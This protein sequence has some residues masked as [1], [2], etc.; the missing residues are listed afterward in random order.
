MQRSDLVKTYYNKVVE[1]YYNRRKKMFTI[2][3]PGSKKVLGYEERVVISNVRFGFRKVRTIDK[4]GKPHY[5]PPLII[6]NLIHDDDKDLDNLKHFDALTYNVKQ[7]TT[8]VT[9]D[10]KKA[11]DLPYH[12]AFCSLNRVGLPIYVGAW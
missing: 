7:N 10:G 8:F 9:F 1:V 11:R 3:D 5:L 6:G 12:A 4:N 2:R